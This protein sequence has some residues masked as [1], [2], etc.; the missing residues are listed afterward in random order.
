MSY[1]RI[2]YFYHVTSEKNKESIFRDQRFNL[3]RANDTNYDRKLAFPNA[4]KVVFFSVSY[5]NNYLPTISPYP[6]CNGN[7][8][9]QASRLLVPYDITRDPQ[10]AYEHGPQRTDEKRPQN[11]GEHGSQNVDEN[12]PQNAGEH[13]PQR[14]AENR[15]QNA[16]QNAQQNKFIPIYI[17]NGAFY[18]LDMTSRHVINIAFF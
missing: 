1:S 5:W 12:E 2:E 18:S 3:N 14:A 16:A 17:S 9:P 8:P 13:G 6:R 11:A 15:L 4:P 10:N 7:C